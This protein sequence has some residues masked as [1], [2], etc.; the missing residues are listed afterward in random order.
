MVPYEAFDSG[1]EINGRVV[2]AVVEKALGK[3]SES[4]QQQAVAALAEEGLV[5][6]GEEDWFPQQ[7]WLNAFETM[8]SNLEPHVLDRLGE[9]IPT[10]AE[11]PNNFASVPEGL[12]SIDEAYQRN[13]RG[14][15]IGFY[16]F[17]QL[18][19]TLGEVQCQ[20]PYPCQFDRGVIRGVAKQYAPV[21]AF[22]FIEETGDACRREG[23]DICTYTVHW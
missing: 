13:H 22:V 15:E 5:D 10:V 1:V 3:F 23:G 6:P 12:A 11:W 18:D 17:E 8:T 20:N 14:G 2:L 9:Q 7:A 4:Y 21:D 19:E 16:R